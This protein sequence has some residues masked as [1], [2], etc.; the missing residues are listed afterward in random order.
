MRL[1]KRRA[2]VTGASGDLGRA[3]VARLL[4][5]GWRVAAQCHQHPQALAELRAEAEAAGREMLVVPADLRDAAAV[6]CM[7]AEVARAFCGIELLVNNAGGAQPRTL[8]E[9]TIQEW[10]DC[11]RL[12]LSAPLLCLRAALPLLQQS[13]GVVVNVA[14]VVAFT[15]G[16]FG[17]HYAAAKAGVIGLTRSAARELG[18]L[19]IRVNAVAPGPVESAMTTALGDKTL[20][21]ILAGTALGRVVRAEEVADAV[22]WLASGG[23][24]LTGQTLVIDGGRAMH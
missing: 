8:R 15:G 1:C 23:T 21:A 10:D 3:M 17:V 18:P 22:A 16:S 11:L 6:E 24:A 9:L 7:V 20:A 12:N 14:S 5:D 2:L 4:R 19:G 13:R